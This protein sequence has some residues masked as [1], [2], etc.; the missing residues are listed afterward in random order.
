LLRFGSPVFDLNQITMPPK[1]IEG[2]VTVTVDPGPSC[3][4]SAMRSDGF[5]GFVAAAFGIALA[6]V[7]SLYVAL[8]FAGIPLH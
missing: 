1:S 4:E 5:P 8:A 3:G 7:L 2:F 6:S